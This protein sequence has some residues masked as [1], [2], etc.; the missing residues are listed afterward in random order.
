MPLMVLEFIP[1]RYAGEHGNDDA[2]KKPLAEL[3]RCVV[4]ADRTARSD[5]TVTCIS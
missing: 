5:S 3:G 4:D 2:N 1:A